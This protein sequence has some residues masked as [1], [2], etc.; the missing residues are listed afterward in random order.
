MSFNRSMD[1]AGTSLTESA[2]ILGDTMAQVLAG[3]ASNEDKLSAAQLKSFHAHLKD[4]PGAIAAIK[5]L[6]ELIQSSAGARAH[7]PYCAMPPSDIS[8][9]RR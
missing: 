5:V 2:A 6:I 3:S 8:G 9:V 1:S 4:E 7:A